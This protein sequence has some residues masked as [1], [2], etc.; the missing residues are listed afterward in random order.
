MSREYYEEYGGTLSD[1]DIQK[2]RKRGK[3]FIEP[4][5]ILQLQPSGYNLTPTKSTAKFT[6]R[7]CKWL[8]CV[9]NCWI[10]STNSWVTS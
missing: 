10:N 5:D 6:M 8:I 9:A 7:Y 1:V 3:I 2:E 4:F